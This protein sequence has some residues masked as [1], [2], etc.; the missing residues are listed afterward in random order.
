MPNIYLSRYIFILGYFYIL[1]SMGK[2]KEVKK[3]TIPASDKEKLVKRVKDETYRMKIKK[4]N[5]FHW[6]I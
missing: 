3:K 2:I 6:K 5:I 1:G 4:P